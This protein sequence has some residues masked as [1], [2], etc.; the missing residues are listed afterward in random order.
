MADESGERPR[1]RL[2]RRKFF[3]LVG[4]SAV[5]VTALAGWKR[6][7]QIAE[8]KASIAAAHERKVPPETFD[9]ERQPSDEMLEKM[10]TQFFQGKE[11]FVGKGAWMRIWGDKR[12]PTEG[13]GRSIGRLANLFFDVRKTEEET[14]DH[15]Y[16]LFLGELQQSANL[17]KIDLP[18]LLVNLQISGENQ[19]FEALPVDV[20]T[21]QK[22]LQMVS[23]ARLLGPGFEN[24]IPEGFRSNGIFTQGIKNWRETFGENS[25]LPKIIANPLYEAAPKNNTNRSVYDLL[26]IKSERSIGMMDYE[27]S[28]RAKALLLHGSD[29]VRNELVTKYPQVVV[30]YQ[31][32]LYKLGT[33]FVPLIEADKYP[34]TEQTLAQKKQL[35]KTLTS[36]Y[37]KYYKGHLDTFAKD[38]QSLAAIGISE[39]HLSNWQKYNRTDIWHQLVRNGK[40][41]AENKEDEKQA[42]I[43]FKRNM[44][45]EYESDREKYYQNLI[46]QQILNPKFIPFLKERVGKGNI[47]E[48]E[49][50]NKLEQAVSQYQE[51]ATS[52]RIAYAE[53][54]L[55]EG[56]LEYDIKFQTLVS[57]VTTKMISD[58]AGPYDP[59]NKHDWY[60][61][62][63]RMAMVREMTTPY[64]TV[65]EGGVAPDVSVDS[66]YLPEVTLSHL[67]EFENMLREAPGGLYEHPSKHIV[68]FIQSVYAFQD[69][70]FD[71]YPDLSEEDRN[72]IRTYFK[73]YLSGY[74]E[75]PDVPIGRAQKNVLNLITP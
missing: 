37:L 56:K 6:N 42:Y 8:A 13:I 57:A 15:F 14:F 30:K 17:A 4:G 10:Y 48:I 20:Q 75:E 3:G 1:H 46:N 5:A 21:S 69:G 51:Q 12:L 53:S 39:D 2:S 68:A 45:V 67:D 9:N 71:M 64:V 29:E 59:N 41:Q 27:E 60:W 38:D 49:L 58:I 11:D 66:P 18:T 23:L 43:D 72:R 34:K 52:V 61:H 19:S 32:V 50:L 25:S 54:E 7:P 33:E 24:Q 26:R 62:L 73:R 40:L 55:E 28:Q 16:E 65:R 31:Q 74:P 47:F 44:D 35:L 63:Y 22:Q 36:E 70:N